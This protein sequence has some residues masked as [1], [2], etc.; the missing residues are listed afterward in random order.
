MRSESEERRQKTEGRRA[1][2]RAPLFC[3]LASAFCL[4]SAAGC[5][6]TH[7]G[8]PLKPN[9]AGNDPG[10][11]LEF[12]HELTTEPVASND[13]AFHGVLLY[14]DGKDVAE[15]YPARVQALRSRK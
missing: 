10:Q 6:S 9:L 11:Q 13:Q 4:L 5:Q 8:H 15:D 1:L 14:L 2:G 12:W 3:L 7:V